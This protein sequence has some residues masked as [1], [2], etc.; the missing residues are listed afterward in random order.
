MNILEILGV[1]CLVLIGI[2]LS[3]MFLLTI[4]DFLVVMILVSFN[5]PTDKKEEKNKEE[6]KDE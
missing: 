6:N 1:I 2:P 5:L 4:V 3:I